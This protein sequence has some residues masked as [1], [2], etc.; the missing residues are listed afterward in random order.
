[1]D[2]IT[3]KVKAEKVCGAE[4]KGFEGNCASSWVSACPR[5]V[6]GILMGGN[7]GRTGCMVAEGI[8]RG[9][10]DYDRNYG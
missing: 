9:E 8:E 10:R 6:L 1:M 4:G 3:D 5:P 2:S 7:G